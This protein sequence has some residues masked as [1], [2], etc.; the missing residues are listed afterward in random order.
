MPEG[1]SYEPD[2]QLPGPNGVPVPGSYG[3]GDGGAGFEYDE[4]TLRALMHEWND[5]A[6]EFE[7]DLNR[8]ALLQRAQGPG[9]E[10]ASNGNAER[11]RASGDALYETLVARAQYCRSMAQRCKTAL[12]KYAATEEASVADLKPTAGSL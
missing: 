1:P 5:L 10:Y 12:G 9:A 7:D 6:N 8:A 11:V 4:E 2:W 3:G